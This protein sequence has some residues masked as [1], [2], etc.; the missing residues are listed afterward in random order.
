MR[1]K[2]LLLLTVT[3]LLQAVNGFSQS[4]DIATLK[5]IN[6]RFLNAIVNADTAALSSV[7]AEDFVLINPGGHK[8]NKAGNLANALSVNPKV[9]SVHIDSVEA[10]LIDEQVGTVT[11]W[12]SF[13][14]QADGKQTTGK[15]CYQDVY[16]KR[17]G[18]WQ[19]VSAHV[20]LLG[21]K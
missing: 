19:A 11:A 2:I 14:I 9:L 17:N 15:N 6:S 5:K 18:R 16:A 3:M 12:T 20:T 10:R 4:N 7:L 1:I 13:V 8:Q 21:I